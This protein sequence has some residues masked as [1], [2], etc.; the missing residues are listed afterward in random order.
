MTH[1]HWLVGAIFAVAAFSTGVIGM[2]AR[3]DP[4]QRSDPPLEYRISE[5]SVVISSHTPV[6]RAGWRTIQLMPGASWAE[7]RSRVRRPFEFTRQQMMEALKA[8][9]AMRFFELASAP[10]AR[11]TI[12]LDDD[13]VVRTSLL[14]P[15]DAGSTRVCFRTASYEKCVAYGAD[16]PEPLVQWVVAVKAD[17]MRAAGV[18]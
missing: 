18:D 4:P 12:R 5:V 2:P 7:D 10:S 3:A 16:A 14:R 17:A 8:L 9:Y 11:R 15:L 6:D 13:G 1:V